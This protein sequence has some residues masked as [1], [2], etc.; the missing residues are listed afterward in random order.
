[1][2]GW[3]P[4]WSVIVLSPVARAGI[5]C[6]CRFCFSRRSHSGARVNWGDGVFLRYV[7]L[8]CADDMGSES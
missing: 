6:L 1:M 5:T 2:G 3:E 4:D 7:L 8:G